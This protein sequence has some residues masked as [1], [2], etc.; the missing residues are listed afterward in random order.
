MGLKYAFSNNLIN[1]M[2]III[3]NKEVTN[4]SNKGLNNQIFVNNT[5]FKKS[6]W[7]AS[8]SKKNFSAPLPNIEGTGVITSLQFNSL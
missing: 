2:F 7:T 5:L 3:L 1:E 6:K 8:F 4:I